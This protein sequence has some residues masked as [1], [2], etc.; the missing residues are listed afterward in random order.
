MML[1]DSF[2]SKPTADIMRIPFIIPLLLLNSWYLIFMHLIFCFLFSLFLKKSYLPIRMKKETGEEQ[3][4][5]F[6]GM[7]A[8]ILILMNFK[9]KASG[10]LVCWVYMQ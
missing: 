1:Y 8:I 6:L 10:T 4:Q 9:K 3:D 2:C 7:C 5:Y